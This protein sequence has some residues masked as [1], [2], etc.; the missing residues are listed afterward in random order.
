M[1]QTKTWRT[2]V[3]AIAIAAAPS[4]C[5]SHD[6]PAAP[7]TPQTPNPPATPSTP[8]GPSGTQYV[9]VMGKQGG[10]IFLLGTDAASGHDDST[11]QEPLFKALD[12]GSPLPVLVVNHE[13]LSKDLPLYELKIPMAFM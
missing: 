2:L 6:S 1:S 9:S 10:T 5:S 3:V 8:S 4:A 13:G 11:F 12:A 7:S